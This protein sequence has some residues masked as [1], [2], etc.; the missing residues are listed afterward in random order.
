MLFRSVVGT[1]ELTD[2]IIRR[3][4]EPPHE[5]EHAAV[6]LPRPQAITVQ[7]AEEKVLRGVDVWI[8]HSISGG[9][10]PEVLGDGLAALC[11]E[12][13]WRL[14]SIID[15]GS[16]AYPRVTPLRHH[17]DA[18]CCRF[19]AASEQEPRF[20]DI[21]TLL[22]KIDAQGFDVTKTHALVEYDGR[23]GWSDSFG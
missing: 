22:A 17:S 18:W 8:D 10:G 13:G 16:I 9:R 2:E 19:F 11:A 14:D 3:I 21:L 23:R 12:T 6:R 15:R 4:L 7:H 20:S 5:S 1:D